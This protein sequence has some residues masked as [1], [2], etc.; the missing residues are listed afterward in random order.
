MW[1]SEDVKPEQLNGGQKITEST[2]VTYDLF[3]SI[4]ALMLRLKEE[5]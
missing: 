3:N 5:I 4:V 1:S 2:P